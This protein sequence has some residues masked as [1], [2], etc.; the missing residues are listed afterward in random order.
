M[1]GQYYEQY[2]ADQ[3]AWGNYAAYQVT[4]NVP[5]ITTSVSKHL[6]WLVEEKKLGWTHVHAKKM[7]SI[8][9]TFLYE[10]CS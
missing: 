9:H 3:A 5:C 2:W 4:F 7:F 10:R 6:A 1:Y 8:V